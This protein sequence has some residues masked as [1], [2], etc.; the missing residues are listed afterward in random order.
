MRQFRASVWKEGDWVIAQC[1]DVDV[2]SQGLTEAEAL[3]SLMDALELHF[4]DP[5]PTETPHLVTLEVAI[6]TV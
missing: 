6:G 4:T 2:A 5:M 3:A 1:L